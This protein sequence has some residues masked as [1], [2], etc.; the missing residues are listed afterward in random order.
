MLVIELI[1]IL[2]SFDAELPIVLYKGRSTFIL[3][4]VKV[5]KLSHLFKIL[6]PIVVTKYGIV[7]DENAHPL[8]ALSSIVVTLFGISK[9]NNDLQL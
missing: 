3:F 8:N 5:F 1:L 6:D 2:V 9:L 4:N 7:N